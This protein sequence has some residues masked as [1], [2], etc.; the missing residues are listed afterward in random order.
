MVSLR[1]RTHDLSRVNP[2]KPLSVTWGY[3]GKTSSGGK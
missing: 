2:F 1:A 3:Q